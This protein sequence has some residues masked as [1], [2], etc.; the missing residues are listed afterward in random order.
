MIDEANA[1]PPSVR[2][3]VSAAPDPLAAAAELHRALSGP[4]LSLVLFFCSAEYE[5]PA[6]AAQLSTPVRRRVGGRL[7][8]RRRDRAGRLPR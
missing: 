4:E 2:R 3:A 6:F 8:R 5:Q 1:V 7:H